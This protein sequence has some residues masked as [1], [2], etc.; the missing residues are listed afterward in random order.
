MFETKS[1]DELS[2]IVNDWIAGGAEVSDGT[3]KFGKSQKSEDDDDVKDVKP[4]PQSK[5]HRTL[6]DAFSDLMDD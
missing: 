4:K 1:Y 2:K 3:E 6:D 5:E